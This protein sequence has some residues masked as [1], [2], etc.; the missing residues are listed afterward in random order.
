MVTLLVAF[1][2]VLLLSLSPLWLRLLL[3]DCRVFLL[4]RS[5]SWCCS[6]SGP[7]LRLLLLG[8]CRAFRL[9][10]GLAWCSPLNLVASLLPLLLLVLADRASLLMRGL[11]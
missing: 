9:R 2:A 11:G 8:D 10:W 3:M 4:R 1:L 6:L 5:V 7:L